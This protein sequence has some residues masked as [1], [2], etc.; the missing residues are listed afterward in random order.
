M[1]RKHISFPINF[2]GMPFYSLIDIT[3]NDQVNPT[4]ISS[5][6]DYYFTCKKTLGCFGS[7]FF[8]LYWMIWYVV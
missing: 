1:Y 5:L 7:I 8:N 3:K 2:K 6:Y 4:R